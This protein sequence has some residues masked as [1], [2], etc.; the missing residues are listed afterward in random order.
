MEITFKQYLVENA[1]SRAITKRVADAINKAT[2]GEF[3]AQSSTKTGS[4][5]SVLAI[6]TKDSKIPAEVYSVFK[7]HKIGVGDKETI[8]NKDGSITLKFFVMEV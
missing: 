2:S 6:T 3:K 1:K 4:L 8:E 5:E 7:Q